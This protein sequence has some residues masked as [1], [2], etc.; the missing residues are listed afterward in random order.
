MCVC[1]VPS[2]PD[3]CCWLLAAGCWLLAAGCRLLAA[4]HVVRV[5]HPPQQ[6]LMQACLHGAS[7]QILPNVFQCFLF[8]PYGEVQRVM[9]K[10][11]DDGG[12][13]GAWQ[14]GQL[15]L[16][17]LSRFGTKGADFAIQVLGAQPS[18]CAMKK[19]NNDIM[20]RHARNGGYSALGL[21]C[22][23][24]RACAKCQRAAST[25]GP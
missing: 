7:S 11:D 6:L 22:K 24:Q 20:H 1:R 4:G 17:L 3:G 8:A 12:S 9:D 18:G 21:A 5:S 15:A 14:P 16:C 19:S 25:H 2:N 13:S 10:L 23:C